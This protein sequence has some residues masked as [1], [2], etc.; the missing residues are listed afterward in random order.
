MDTPTTLLESV[1]KWGK[2]RDLDDF[3]IAT[4]QSLAWYYST[5]HDGPDLPDG[6]W[7][8]IAVRAVCNGRDLP[9]CGTGLADA[10]SHPWQ[11]AGMAE[12][13][14]EESDGEK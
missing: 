2:K 5:R 12:E 11:G 1:L 14:K 9:G 13:R 8:R 3:E 7:A 10:L 6:H 4:A